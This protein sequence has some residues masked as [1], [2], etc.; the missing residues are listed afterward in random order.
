MASNAER[1]HYE[2]LERKRQMEMALHADDAAGIIADSTA[3]RTALIARMQAGEMTL[4]QVQAELAR[5]QREA[6][7]AGKPVRADYFKR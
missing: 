5:I 1:R 6:K 7:K 3:V 4:E 2:R